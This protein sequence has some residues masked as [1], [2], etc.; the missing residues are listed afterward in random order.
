MFAKLMENRRA[1]GDL[2]A[3]FPDALASMEAVRAVPNDEIAGE[4]FIW[5][6]AQYRTTDGEKWDAA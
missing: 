4:V 3:L 5:I 1:R 2:F 6:S